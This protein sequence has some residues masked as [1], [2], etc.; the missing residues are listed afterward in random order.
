VG[1]QKLLIIGQLFYP[2]LVSTGKTVTELAIALQKQDIEITVWCGQ[3]SLI[4]NTK[5]TK[6]KITYKGISI[7]RPWSTQFP[8]NSFWGKLLNHL[9]FSLSVI[10]KLLLS[11]EKSPILVFTNPPILSVFVILIGKWKN[12]DVTYVL[13]DLYPDTLVSCNVLKPTHVLVKLWKKINLLCYKNAKNIIV[14]GRCMKT[15][16]LKKIPQKLHA[17]VHHINIWAT[18]TEA[19]SPKTPPPLTL[20]Y[21]GNLG[22]FHDIETFAY[23]AKHLESLNPN[24]HWLFVGDGYKKKWLLDF[25]NDQKIKTIT[26]K[27]FI[28][29]KELDTLITTSHVGLV[30]L[31]P[32]QIGLSVPS[33]SFGILSAGKP[34]LAVLPSQCE[35]AQI[36]QE[37]Q[38][39]MVVPPGDMVALSTAIQKLYNDPEWRE[40]L[41][42]N[43]KKAHQEKYNVDLAATAYKKLIFNT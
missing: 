24:I 36:I 20:V 4:P 34:L 11:T 18:I 22:R 27:G 39:G 28:D 9:T 10:V 12:R 17:K 3:P 5:K 6:N 41:G 42:K 2:E 26:Y 38:C 25:I 37:N 23:T 8:K 43:A 7:L 13:F 32:E 33:K 35:I 14:L 21:A 1:N 19:T 16:V 29:P 40:Q 30:S 31:L 15:L